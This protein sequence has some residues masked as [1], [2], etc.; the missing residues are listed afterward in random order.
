MIMHLEV[1]EHKSVG[2]L[3]CRL[4]SLYGLSCRSSHSFPNKKWESR[5]SAWGRGTD[6][7]SCV[8]K[9]VSGGSDTWLLFWVTSRANLGSWVNRLPGSTRLIVGPPHSAV[10]VMSVTS[11]RASRGHQLFAGVHTFVLR[12]QFFGMKD[13]PVTRHSPYN[14]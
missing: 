11:S 3:S 5:V 14:R 9:L 7:I 2:S 8:C 1:P 13:C 4:S 10:A 6:F 12:S